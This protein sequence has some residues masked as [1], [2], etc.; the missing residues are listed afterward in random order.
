MAVFL[1]SRTKSLLVGTG[2]DNIILDSVQRLTSALPGINL[3][4]SP[5]T[6]YV[7][8]T[9]VVLAL[10]VDFANN[11]S[12]AEVERATKDLQIAI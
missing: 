3:I 12:A 5:I 9:N 11:L 2:V 7:G 8:L 1:V 10:D 6:M 4:C